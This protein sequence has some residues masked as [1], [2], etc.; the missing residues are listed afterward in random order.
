MEV[1]TV[2]HSCHSYVN[3]RTKTLHKHCNTQSQALQSG[4]EEVGAGLQP[5]STLTLTGTSRFTSTSD[6]LIPPALKLIINGMLSPSQSTSEFHAFHARFVHIYSMA[7][8]PK[9]GVRHAS[10]GFRKHSACCDCVTICII[11]VAS[12]LMTCRRGC[13]YVIFSTTPLTSSHPHSSRTGCLFSRL[14]SLVFD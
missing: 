6:L 1:A 8:L 9:G 14:P 2:V 5:M 3:V 13:Q 12:W 4:W 7:S 11:R 10:R